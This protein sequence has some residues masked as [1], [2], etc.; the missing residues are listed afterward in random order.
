MAD[1]TYD[2]LTTRKMKQAKP[3]AADI[4]MSNSHHQSGAIISDL[5][6]TKPYHR[7]RRFFPG[8]QSPDCCP[9]S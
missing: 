7:R 1:T 3:V 5:S 2:S 9:M 8:M 6:V 4:Q